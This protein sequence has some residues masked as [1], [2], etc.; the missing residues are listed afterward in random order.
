MNTKKIYIT[1]SKHLGYS[2]WNTDK[3]PFYY[4]GIFK[5]A[6]YPYTQYEEYYVTDNFVEIIFGS[7]NFIDYGE[8]K[9]ITIDFQ[10]H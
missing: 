7:P 3:K 5:N 6:N 4:D 10:G 8:C 9:E 1:R 2:I